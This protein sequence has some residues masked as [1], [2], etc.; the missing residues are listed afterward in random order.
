MKMEPAHKPAGGPVEG[1][2]PVGEGAY[3]VPVA[4]EAVMTWEYICRVCA[5]EGLDKLDRHP[6]C[7]K[8]YD[9]WARPIQAKYGGLEAYIKAYRLQWSDDALP[10]EYVPG[11]ITSAICSD[12]PTTNGD[13]STRIAAPPTS[14]PKETQEPSWRGLYYFHSSMPSTMAKVIPNDWP[15]GVP[16]DCGHYVVWCRLPILHPSLFS[17]PDTPFP[18]GTSRDALY[19][20]V[21]SDGIRGLTGHMA[22]D[23]EKGDG[24]FRVI[25]EHTVALLR[26]SKEIDTFTPTPSATAS[27]ML[28]PRMIAIQAA[29]HLNARTGTGPSSGSRTSAV[30]P[31]ILPPSA[32]SVPVVP[33]SSA[34]ALS[35]TGIGTANALHMRTH[36]ADLAERAQAWAGRHV[37]SFVRRTWPPDQ[38][39]QTAWFCNPPHLRTVPGLSHFHVIVRRQAAPHN[40]RQ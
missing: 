4:E 21:V 18:K 29:S 2:G 17:T 16:A 13:G 5:R 30:D 26:K 6:R 38:G 31:P 32:L 40:E 15:Y 36:A 39:W 23:R 28:G 19:E 22:T 11:A 25:G 1:T 3:H 20:A 8:R 12:A 27:P 14:A 24:D 7:Q 37:D 10:E 33:G 35:G 9:D 34:N